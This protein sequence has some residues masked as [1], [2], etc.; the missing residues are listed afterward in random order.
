M[1][2]GQRVARIGN[3]GRSTGPHLHY[4]VQSTGSP[5]P[6][7]FILEYPLLNGCREGR[8]LQRSRAERAVA[9]VAPAEQATIRQRAGVAVAGGDGGDPRGESQ[10]GN[11]G[12]VLIVVEPFPISP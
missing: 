9:V 6:R 2:R 3:T 4:E 7:K 8:V 12:I 10:D 5:R 11:R 1:K